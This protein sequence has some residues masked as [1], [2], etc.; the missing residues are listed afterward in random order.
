MKAMKPKKKTPVSDFQVGEQVFERLS[1]GVI[2]LQQV[3][4][5]TSCYAF[6]ASGKCIS[7]TPTKIG[8]NDFY[9][10][11]GNSVKFQKANQ[12]TI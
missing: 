1:G 11:R 10:E 8:G 4:R 5:V 2:W 6:L 7:R 3:V 12:S 9:Y